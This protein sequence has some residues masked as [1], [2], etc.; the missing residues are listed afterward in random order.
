MRMFE[1]NQKVLQMQGDR[2]S[3][4][5]SDLSGTTSS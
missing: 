1:S 5:I 4:T 2:M 3:K